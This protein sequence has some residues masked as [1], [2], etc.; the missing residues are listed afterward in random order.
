M[1]GTRL[2]DLVMSTAADA[3]I[4]HAFMLTGGFAMH[5]NDALAGEA[6]IH[7]TCCH[8]EQGAAYA[9]EGY[10][11]ITGL[12]ALLQITAGPGAINAMAGVFGAYV[13]S[14]PMLVVSGQN[15]REMT[16]AHYGFDGMRQIGDQ[17][18]DIVSMARPITKYAR[19]ITD[20][21]RV[22]FEMQKALHLA[23]SGRPGPVW[24][25]IP[26][27]V[28]DSRVNMALLPRYTPAR[29]PPPDAAAAAGDIMEKISASRRPLLVV[30]PDVRRPGM[31][32]CLRQCAAVLNLPIVLAGAQDAVP[33]EHPLYAGSM[34][35]VGSRAGNIAMQNADLILFVGMR[36]YLGLVTYNWKRLG[37]NA[38]KI[39]VDEDPYEFEKPCQIADYAL[40]CGQEHFLPAL[41]QAAQGCP[42]ERFA[43]WRDWCRERLRLLPA[44]SAELRRVT[45]AGRINPYWFVEELYQLMDADDI[46]VAG[47]ASSSV[48]P[49]QAGRLK[50][51]QR[52]F[53][54]H[55][56]GA[57]GF[58]LPAAIGAAMAA[59][60]RRI[61]CLEGDGSLMLNI[62]E[63]QTV[64]HHKLPIAIIVF[65]NDGYLSIRQTQ[66]N[67]FGRSIGADA[68]SGTSL[69]DFTA[70][71]KS[72]GLDAARVSGANFRRDMAE[73]LSRPGPVLVDVMLDMEQG[74]EPKVASRRM[75]D[76]TMV[77]A[78]PEDMFPFLEPEDLAGHMRISR[79][80]LP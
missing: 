18:A 44:V 75:P 31:A 40:Q 12:P 79:G 33:H 52:F 72:F 16:R 62:Q 42:H 57:M 65:N 47:N 20:P 30:G 15:K 69:P 61:I 21:T 9:A 8:H 38:H 70:V 4:S 78:A 34:G 71:A 58:A 66:K 55:G 22:L 51:G 27:D 11:H 7:T 36:P 19:Q 73:I 32:E 76:G 67:F 37:E 43:E 17:E 64:V 80:P 74:F 26:L 29:I 46:I 50:A 41:L 63:L 68:A 35:I 13:D 48:I 25:D 39:V 28:Q 45:D 24:L 60:E 1:S 2:A 14:I 6:R 59:P 10:G 53:S 56:N 5:L 23:V 77:S 3:G 49:L 54:N